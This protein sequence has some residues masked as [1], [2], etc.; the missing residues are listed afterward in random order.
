MRL[1][2]IMLGCSVLLFLLIDWRI[3][4]A[5]R[6][7]CASKVPA[8]LQ[9]VSA[10]ILCAILIVT[11]CLPRR[12]GSD[13][14]LL[15]IMW[16]LFGILSVYIAKAVFVIVDFIGCL[17]KFFG[18]KRIRCLSLT[19]GILAVLTFLLV[20]WG[21]LIN[22][23]RVDVREVDV[24]VPDLPEAFEGYRI[25][26]FSDLHTGTYGSDT[27]FV[28]HLVNCIDALDGD[29]VVFTGDIVNRHTDEILPHVQALSRL[30]APDGVY[31]ILGNHDY[32]DY[33]EWPSAEAKQRNL[34]DLIDIQRSMG[35][36]LLLNEHDAVVRDGDSI[37]I[38]GVENVGD[39]PFTTYGSLPDAYSSPSDSNTKILLSHNPAHWQRDI[40]K[41][42]T[43]NIA[44]TLSGHTHAMQIE[45]FGHSPASFRYRYWGGL[46]S[47]PEDDGKR[48]LYVNIG[49]G[50][51]GIPMRLG[52]T[53]ELTVI[54]LHR[55]ETKK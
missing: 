15:C 16:S 18:G 54:T 25:V 34:K 55:A 10:L 51:V 31:S 45:A 7:R 41:C 33:S 46:Y 35:W 11:V 49:A 12:D 50:T 37:M 20:W 21:A 4:A 1:P 23:F 32:G 9:L 22:R 13:S 29:M 2:L 8:R 3:Y 48:Q 26:Q 44:L 30:D 24:E 17:P 47:D 14:Q 53:P 27:T 5:A 40:A 42:D 39:P 36:H 38:I 52:A 19:G 43:M 6:H 28:S